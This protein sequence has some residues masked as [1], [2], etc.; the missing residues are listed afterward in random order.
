MTTKD[1][2]GGHFNND[3][4]NDDDNE[5]STS[6]AALTTTTA[7][8]SPAKHVHNKTYPSPTL[9]PSHPSSSSLHPKGDPGEA[10]SADDQQTDANTASSVQTQGGVESP[11]IDE[12]QTDDS[13]SSS[14]QPSQEVEAPLVDDKQSDDIIILSTV[15]HGGKEVTSIDDDND[16]DDDEG[17][18][19][20][21]DINSL[22]TPSLL[23]SF[24]ARLPEE[25]SSPLLYD[26]AVSRSGKLVIVTDS[27][28]RSVKAFDLTRPGAP[29]CGELRL[30]K[31][32]PLCLTSL[33]CPE[34]VVVTLHQRPRLFVLG[35]HHNYHHQERDHHQEQESL[36]GALLGV[37]GTQDVN[38][39]HDNARE[40]HEEE[41]QE[42][43][44]ENDK[45]NVPV[46][47]DRER[48]DP[49]DIENPQD[50]KDPQ[51]TKDP[52]D[53]KDPH[54]TKDPQDKKDPGPNP[55]R[56]VL[57]FHSVI[58]TCCQYRGISAL[59][60]PGDGQQQED[61]EHEQQQ[62]VLTLSQEVHVVSLQ[63]VVLRVIAPA[64]CGLPLLVDVIHVT[65]T[66]S[67]HLV[68]TDVGARRVVCLT[69]SGRVRWLHPSLHAPQRQEKE[70]LQD[71]DE[72][73]EKEKDAASRD[74][75]TQGEAAKT[76]GDGSDD[77]V[78]VKEKEKKVEEEEEE[79]VE[80]E[81]EEEAFT[82][83]QWPLGVAADR[84]GRVFVSDLER[85]SVVQLS[86]GGVV[87][88]LLLTRRHAL[89]Y[90]RGL[91]VQGGCLCL[92][93]DD[94]VKV[95]SLSGRHGPCRAPE[96]S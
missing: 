75:P 14:A 30:G 77:G 21:S 89:H 40:I 70:D 46:T 44:E 59:G 13:I 22:P 33:S 47:E 36:P 29:C 9:S 51:D 80:E 52:Q 90:P 86:P 62:L 61:E 32:C 15:Q 49:Q 53:A 6:S 54:D 35:V 34:R 68:V 8:D 4:D 95:F 39:A 76:D 27:W 64:L 18:E 82:G 23:H 74:T 65:A 81:E 1:L 12:E 48:N 25:G 88:R 79:E 38:V 2:G 92:T 57:Y 16:N 19:E 41:E 17:E 10:R 43:E 50:I 85:H 87:G 7:V 37:S 31:E 28:N 45:Q 5:T 78:K 84:Q 91:A 63:G 69:L 58:T 72:E 20:H 56:P 60:T 66:P 73:E 96:P 3:N 93:Q 71:M 11:T 26:V 67:R 42:Q 83:V 24:G 55:G 94:R